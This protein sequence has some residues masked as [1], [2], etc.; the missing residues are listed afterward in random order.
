MGPLP[1]RRAWTSQSLVTISLTSSCPNPSS[2]P[3]LISQSPSRSENELATRSD[4]LSDTPTALTTESRAKTTSKGQL[5]PKLQ[6]VYD[7]YTLG[8]FDKANILKKLTNLESN[9]YTSFT[10]KLLENMY[11][12]VFSKIP[13]DIV[14][15]FQFRAQIISKESKYCNFFQLEIFDKPGNSGGRKGDKS[16]LES[17]LEGG[18]SDSGAP[19]GKG[20]W[21]ES[22]S[23]KLPRLL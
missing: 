8:F 4:G 1:R 22:G 14:L 3:T 21:W 17:C 16:T 10:G 9:Q 7:D 12:I 15:F 5:F 18:S 20:K 23:P 11:N 6:Y 2:S 19:G 13:K